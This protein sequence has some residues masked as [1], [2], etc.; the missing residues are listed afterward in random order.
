MN[1][2]IRWF[3]NGQLY[4]TKNYQNKDLR[5]IGLGSNDLSGWDFS[6]QNLTGGSFASSTLANANLH[7]ANLTNVSLQFSQLTGANLTAIEI[8]LSEN[9][10]PGAD[11][12]TTEQSIQRMMNL[13]DRINNRLGA[14]KIP[15]QPVFTL[16]DMEDIPVGEP[17]PKEGGEPKLSDDVSDEE[18]LNMY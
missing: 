7:N 2:V 1:G 11:G 13:Q 16:E 10:D 8:G 4:S 17:K 18:L 6:S 5:G 12:I 14:M 9:W 15:E 3:V